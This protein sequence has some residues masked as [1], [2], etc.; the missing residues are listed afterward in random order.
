MAAG[1]PSPVGT[2]P[3]SQQ[4]QGFL[5]AG[6]AQPADKADRPQAVEVVVMPVVRPVDLQPL[7]EYDLACASRSEQPVLQ[8]HLGR[9]LSG[10]KRSFASGRSVILDQAPD[11]RQALVKG[12]PPRLWSRVAVPATVRPLRAQQHIDEMAD[13]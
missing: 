10:L 9:T 4:I 6:V 5:R 12:R 2:L 8:Q 7:G 1:A 13:A 3:R 11:R